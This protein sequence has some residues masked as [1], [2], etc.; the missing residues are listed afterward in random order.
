MSL[1]LKSLR[2]ILFAQGPSVVV[3]ISTG[4]VAAVSMSR[5][6]GGLFLKAYAIEPLPEEAIV[7][8][9]FRA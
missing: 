9:V 2:S 6:K 4:F 1:I 8:K 7:P 5:N 3:E